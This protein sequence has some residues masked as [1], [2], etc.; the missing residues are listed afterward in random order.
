MLHALEQPLP[1]V[2]SRKPQSAMRTPA[3]EQAAGTTRA[4]IRPAAA[5]YDDGLLPTAGPVIAGSYGLALV[6]AALTFMSNGEAMFAVAI[7]SVFA[8]V[9]FALAFL[10]FMVRKHRDIRWQAEGRQKHA[11]EVAIYTGAIRRREALLQMTIVPL[12]VVAAFTV[13]ALIWVLA[14]P[15]P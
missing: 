13:F 10:I 2:T 12:S 14:R 6:I 11:G 3:P 1:P 9:Y 7:S 5:D 8:A 15:F 4:P